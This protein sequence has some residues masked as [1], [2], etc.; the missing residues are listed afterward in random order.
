MVFEQQTQALWLRSGTESCYRPDHVP[1]QDFSRTV[2]QAWTVASLQPAAGTVSVSTPGRITTGRYA[3]T[4]EVRRCCAHGACDT[5]ETCEGKTVSALLRC[6]STT[7]AS[8]FGST[9]KSCGSQSTIG[10][11]AQKN[12]RAAASSSCGRYTSSR[13][14]CDG[15]RDGCLRATP[16]TSDAIV[17]ASPGSRVMKRPPSVLDFSRVHRTPL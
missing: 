4:S 2:N 3:G 8:C 17:P 16:T 10:A 7:S 14:Q 6:V 13:S 9:P 12:G 5:T 15:R 11:V 1:G